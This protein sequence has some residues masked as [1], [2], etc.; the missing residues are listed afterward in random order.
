[1]RIM[2]DR[3]A[4]IVVERTFEGVGAIHGVTFDGQAVW[5]AHGSQGDLVSMEPE[6]GAV[7]A[8]LQ[9]PADAG[10]AFDG[11]H[12]WVAGGD[13]IRKID[14]ATGAAVGEVPGFDATPVS[15]L[16]WADGAL[17]AGVYAQKQI[18]KI[19]PETGAVL[20][21]LVSDRLV[22]G[23]TWADGD[24]WHGVMREENGA[25]SEIRRVDAQSGAVLDRLTLPEGVALSGVEA[26]ANERFWCG[27]GR[28]GKLRAVKRPRKSKSG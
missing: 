20:R 12:L 26:D 1:M 27:D 11:R 22:T 28:S 25:P 3:E 6:T 18:L 13:R 5:F 14:P 21:T 24:L 15:G 9:V 10:V 4:E 7:L 19:D 17:Y 16:A 23:I 2:A 8:R